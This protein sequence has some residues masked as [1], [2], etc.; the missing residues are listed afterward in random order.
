[1]ATR[2]PARL[3]AAHGRRFGLTVGTAFLLLALIAWW[4]AHP[5]AAAVLGG[6]GGILAL[7]GIAVPT[8]LGPV[9]RAWMQLAHAVSRVTTPVVMG[10]LYLLVLTPVG[11]LRRALSRNPLVHREVDSSYWR[12]RPEGARRSASMERQF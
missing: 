6:L 8:R 4:R 3:N 11:I 12:R 5:T 9:E 10:I 1:M 2:I 7:A